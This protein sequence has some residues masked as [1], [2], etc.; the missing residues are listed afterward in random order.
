MFL[1]WNNS[2]ILWPEFKMF[3]TLGRVNLSLLC[4]QNH[5]HVVDPLSERVLT[6]STLLPLI[7]V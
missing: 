4:I 6:V 2:K 7:T 5:Y 1:K 3:I